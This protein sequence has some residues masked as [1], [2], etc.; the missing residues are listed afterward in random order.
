MYHVMVSINQSFF[1]FSY[2]TIYEQRGNKTILIK[3]S[4]HGGNV[5]RY[6]TRIAFKKI[7][8]SLYIFRVIGMAS[9][10]IQ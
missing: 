7:E 2:C 5:L 1:L 10:C 9:M 6:Y 3:R 8:R 4:C